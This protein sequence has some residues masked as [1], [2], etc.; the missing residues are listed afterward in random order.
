M[1]NDR[2]VYLPASFYHQHHLTIQ[3]K[4]QVSNRT[5]VAQVV[6][7]SDNNHLAR[8]S[9][10]LAT[11][12]SVPEHLQW[13]YRWSSASGTLRLG[14]VVAILCRRSVKSESTSGTAGELNC[15]GR[16]ST[17]L[18]GLFYLVRPDD[19]DTKV[20]TWPGFHYQ[21][22]DWISG[23]YPWPQA[24]YD[25]IY[26]RK[27]E[28]R[29]EVIA[30]KQ[31][32]NHITDNRYFNPRYFNKWEINQALHRTDLKRLIPDTRLVS[33]LSQV[34]GMVNSYGG[35]YLK[36]TNGTLGLGIMRLTRT[37][38]GY[39]LATSKGASQDYSSLK[40]AY[41]AARSHMSSTGYLVQQEIKL[42]RMNGN[43]VDVRVLIQKDNSGQFKITKIF[44]RV[45]QGNQ[46][47]TNLATGGTALPLNKVI[48]AATGKNAGPI[49]KKIRTSSYQ[50]ATSLEKV[51]GHLYGELG[52][53]LGIDRAGW[54]WIIEVNSKPRRAVETEGNPELV[55]LSYLRP[56]QYASYLTG[57]YEV[58]HHD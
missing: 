11:A 9:P 1:F 30:A 45:A 18:P 26:S 57:F 10:G 37:T 20:K 35:V 42:M 52:I 38:N 58:A 34:H 56:L 16:I 53:D 17:T 19:V 4:V 55:R 50:I 47:V 46:I 31:V 21:N 15:L 32:L 41:E 43:P 2:I 49:L 7:T 14:P 54:V 39:R 13:H 40:K 44:A 36:P 33:S 25:Q 22:K 12:L 8:L 27:S 48:Y 6:T 51:S 23:T 5:C 24:V 28:K 29:E 3:V